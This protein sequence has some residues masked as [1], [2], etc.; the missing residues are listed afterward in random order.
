MR[1]GA[2]EERR[3]TPGRVLPARPDVEGDK[4]VPVSFCVECGSR[5]EP[6]EA[7]GRVRQV[8]PTCG[9]VH[10]EDPKVGVG[11]VATRDGRILLTR[12]NHEPKL[13]EW[14]FPARYRRCR[15]KRG[16]SCR[17]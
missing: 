9:H 14:S 12:R 2:L 5:L 15:R 17:S 10:F 11:V 8:C 16:R 13:G 4:F 6:R 7:F 1:E 3:R